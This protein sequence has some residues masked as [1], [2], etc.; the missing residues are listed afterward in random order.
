MIPTEEIN[1][2][3]SQPLL[4][5]IKQE[6]DDA[7]IGSDVEAN[8]IRST[9]DSKNRNVDHNVLSHTVDGQPL[10]KRAKVEC[11]DAE[12]NTLQTGEFL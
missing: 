9:T 2:N 7:D 6:N 4:T 8:N 5:V 10:A 12:S 1:N 3:A 11:V